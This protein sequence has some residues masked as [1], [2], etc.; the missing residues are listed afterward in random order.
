VAT[1]GGVFLGQYMSSL[2][3]KKEEKQAEIAS[4]EAIQSDLLN[5]IEKV[6][7]FI[8]R[9]EPISKAVPPDDPVVDHG[10]TRFFEENLLYYPSSIKRLIDYPGKDFKLTPLTLSIIE[11]HLRYLDVLS[12]RITNKRKIDSE[13]MVSLK[14][15]WGTLGNI[16]AILEIERCRIREIASDVEVKTAVEYLWPEENF[17]VPIFEGCKINDLISKL[18]KSAEQKAPSH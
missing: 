10:N 2:E 14:Q 1:A 4:I 11:E 17:K 16:K 8:T 7:G 13:L 9:L 3:T 5:K 18:R 6:G 12:P 15:Y